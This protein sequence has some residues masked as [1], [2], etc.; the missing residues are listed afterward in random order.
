M[1][2][3][4]VLVDRDFFFT[5]LEETHTS[6]IIYFI[7]ENTRTYI[8]YFTTLKQNENSLQELK[9]F[10]IVSLVGSHTYQQAEEKQKN[11]AFSC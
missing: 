11:V 4:E 9:D 3:Y 5:R 10:C 2:I 8:T 1:D 6:Y 7:Y